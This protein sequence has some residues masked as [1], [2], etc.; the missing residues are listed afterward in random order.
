[1]R[2]ITDT[3]PHDRGA[4]EALRVAR[5]SLREGLAPTAQRLAELNALRE[6]IYLG[7]SAYFTLTEDD[8]WPLDRAEGWLCDALRMAL[9]R[10]AA[11]SSY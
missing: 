11:G 8:G 4:A 2:V 6:G 9:L 5:A 7:N 1:M 3:A 10:P